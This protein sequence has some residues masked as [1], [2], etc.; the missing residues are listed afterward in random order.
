LDPSEIIGK[1]Y[2]WIKI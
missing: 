2:Y 1:M